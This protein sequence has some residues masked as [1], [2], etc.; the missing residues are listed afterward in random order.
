[1]QLDTT[2]TIVNLRSL[3][4]NGYFAF[5]K[6]NTNKFGG[7]YFGYGTK[8]SELPFMNNSK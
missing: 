3:L 7:V 1:M 6:A 5:H 4:W 2:K 8:N